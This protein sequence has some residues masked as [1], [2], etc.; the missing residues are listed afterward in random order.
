MDLQY[1]GASPP[2]ADHPVF[3]EQETAV[4]PQILSLLS[5]L[6]VEETRGQ[7]LETLSRNRES[8]SSFALA[9]WNSVGVVTVLLQ[10]I[11]S[12]YHLLVPPV[13]TSSQ[14]TRVNHALGLLQVIATHSETKMWLLEANLHLYLFPFLATQTQTKPYEY[15]RLSSLAVVGALLKSDLPI[16]VPML[17]KTEIVPLCLRIMDSCQTTARTIATFTIQRIISD[18]SGLNYLK[19]HPD[20]LS[21]L[22]KVL[23]T[24]VLVL[25][26]KKN[27]KG[28]D[29][30][31]KK[32]EPDL[33]LLRLVLRCWTRL[34][35]SGD[36]R[37]FFSGNP[38]PAEVLDDSLVQLFGCDKTVVKHHRLLRELISK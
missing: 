20:K 26:S 23:K 2:P 38:L 5:E 25:I 9:L 16:V 21:N 22:H 28:R 18:E 19:N 14:S 17:L 13:L 11:L 4:S 32:D 10:E 1:L 7:A 33:Q 35:E 31:D 34:A 12:T 37:A 6:L 15:L 24:N 36:N 3:T 30:E 29:S 8:Y 27:S